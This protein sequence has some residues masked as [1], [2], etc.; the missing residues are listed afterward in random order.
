MTLDKT[1]IVIARASPENP[2]NS[3]ASMIELRDGSI[4]LGYQEYL[5][6]PAGGGD[7]GLNRLVTVVSRDG[8]LTWSGKRLRVTNDPGD[9]NVYSSNLLRLP[10]GGILFAFM[11]Y[12][13]LE[14][15]KPPATSLY[16]S[17][18]DD[19]GETFGKPVPVWERQPAGCAS[20][21]MK[22]LRNGRIL[23]PVERQ[24]GATWSPTDHSVIGLMISD[25]GGRS[26][27]DSGSRIDLPLRGAME[28]HVEELRD[29][30]ILMV[31]RTQL[32]AVFQSLSADG[33]ET[34][35]KPQT[36]GLRQPETCPELIRLSTGDL[37]IVW[38]NAEYDPRF[39]SHYGKRSPLTAALS[40]DEGATWTHVRNLADNPRTGY[41]NP[42]AFCTGKGRVIVSYSETPYDDKWRM[43]S[44]DNHLRAA[45]F[46]ADWLYA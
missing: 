14:G 15:G 27:R 8:G 22:R 29:G 7:N 2:R 17:R 36:T 40:R 9:V 32:G 37:M 43:T 38:C 44:S 28:G 45:V 13:V 31:L 46:D 20:G 10:D 41:Y 5:P 18:S 42:V 30:R 4:L 19:E 3:E 12:H 33:G 39:G 1:D 25:D 26:W 21:V 16:A 34:W 24:T 35:S 6:G 23:L 11:R